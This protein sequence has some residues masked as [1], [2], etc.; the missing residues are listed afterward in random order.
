MLM[1]PRWS[2]TGSGLQRGTVRGRLQAEEWSGL[3]AVGELADKEV[4]N[5]IACA[6]MWTS[7]GESISD[8]LDGE[9]S[10]LCVLRIPT[11][12]GVTNGVGDV[13]L[14]PSCGSRPISCPSSG[15]EV[16]A[17]LEGPRLYADLLAR[18]AA[19]GSC[20]LLRFGL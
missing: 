10:R 9:V 2:D 13:A 8:T 14:A 20:D 4:V 11:R 12:S 3:G 1:F 5:G 17:D 7:S 15:H 19:P 16:P 18:D 6:A